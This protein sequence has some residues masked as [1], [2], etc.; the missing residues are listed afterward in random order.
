MG[1][2]LNAVL[3]LCIANLSIYLFVSRKPMPVTLNAGFVMPSWFDIPSLQF[4]SAQDEEGIRKAAEDCK[5]K[6]PPNVYVLYVCLWV[7][8]VFVLGRGIR[9]TA[10]DCKYKDPLVFMFCLSVYPS[11]WLSKS[12]SMRKEKLQK[13]ISVEDPHVLC[14]VWLSSSLTLWERNYKVAEDYYKHKDPHVSTSCLSSSVYSW[15]RN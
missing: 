9:K 5:Y 15:R 6:R 13:T 7:C 14:P 8:Q 4:Q 1:A 11:V 12:L 3:L 2:V 10:Q